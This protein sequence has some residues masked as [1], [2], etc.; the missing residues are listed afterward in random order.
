MLCVHHEAVIIFHCV[1]LRERAVVSHR[2]DIL[3]SIERPI[4]DFRYAFR[5][6]N[7]CKCIALS[8]CTVVNFY[9]TFGN[10]KF[11]QSL[12]VHSV[13]QKQMFRDIHE[14]VIVFY[15]APLCERTAVMYRFDI[16]ALS[17][18]QLP[19]FRYAFRNGYACKFYAFKERK[20]ADLRHSLGNDDVFDCTPVFNARYDRVF[21]FQ[22]CGYVFHK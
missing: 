4:L 3:A 19:D 8:E 1:P 9:H 12:Y 10:D 11:G 20:V 15:C 6:D 18:R 5:N 22:I 13:A 14:L 2:L 21:D 16:L 7:T 17:E